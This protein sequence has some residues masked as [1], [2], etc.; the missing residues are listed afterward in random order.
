VVTSP[1]GFNRQLVEDG[2]SGFWAVSAE[3]WEQRLAALIE[4]PELRR[5]MGERGREKVEGEYSLGVSSG[6]LA[7]LLRQLGGAG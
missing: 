2:Q 5:R 1:V 3:E 7:Q 6:K 4:S